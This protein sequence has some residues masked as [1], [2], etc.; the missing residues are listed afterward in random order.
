MAEAVGFIGIGIMGK[1]M[2]NNL[3]KGG[4]SLIVWNRDAKKA[5]ELAEAHEGKVTVCKS[6]AE[7]VQ[8]C[9]LIYSCLSTLEASTA[10]WPE[11]QEA[12][13]AGKMLVDCATLTPER[14]AFMAGA[15]S[16]KGAK[17]LEAPVSGSKGPAE[18]GQLIFLTAGDAACKEA[19]KTDMEA[20][21]KA[22]FYFGADMGKGSK[23]KMVVN[24]IMGVQLNACSEG[25]AL[26]EA[27]DLPVTDMIEI[28]KLGAMNSPMIGLKCPT[29]MNKTYAPAFPLKHAQK[30]MR[31]ALQ[32]G[33]DVGIA[34]PLA[35]AS[36]EEY[37]KARQM[38][39]ADD[40]FSAVA[41][42]S[43]GANGA[44]KQRTS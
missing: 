26:A 25:M 40:D 19:S 8:K 18:A 32:M 27:M 12:L 37:K 42:A 11:V 7:V 5:E 6:A 34:L 22:T 31:F 39:Y 38:G 9:T 3:I 1:G 10:V 23:M 21:G 30:D 2:C 44:K 17:F 43:R 29:M 4:R 28:L 33:D 41:E 13:S 14:M 20:M 36:N 15:T 16:A 35:A 24:M